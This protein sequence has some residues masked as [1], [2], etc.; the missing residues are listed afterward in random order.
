MPARKN[1]PLLELKAECI[2]V[3][4]FSTKLYYYKIQYKVENTQLILHQKH[5]EIATA[6]SSGNSAASDGGRPSNQS[7]EEKNSSNQPT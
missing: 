3:I 1:L 2:V 6:K 7:V 5:R 4:I